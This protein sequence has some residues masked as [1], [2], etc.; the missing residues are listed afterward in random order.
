MTNLSLHTAHWLHCQY[1]M[2]T[3]CFARTCFSLTALALHTALPYH[4]ALLTYCPATTYF[5]I[6]PL[7]AFYLLP[8][9]YTLLYPATSYC[10]LTT[11]QLYN[12]HWLPCHNILPYPDWLPCYYMLLIDHPATIYCLTLPQYTDHRPHRHCILL[13]D[14]PAATYSSITSLSLHIVHWLPCHYILSYPATT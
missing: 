9:Y 4:Y 11:L 2:L 3:D 13:T 6:L 5:T 12:A 14:H 10:S 1:T 7:H 8:Y